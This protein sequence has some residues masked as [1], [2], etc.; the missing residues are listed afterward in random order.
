MWLLVLFPSP[1]LCYFR[2]FYFSNVVTCNKVS[3]IFRK[4]FLLLSHIYVVLITPTY[5]YFSRLCFTLKFVDSSETFQGSSLHQGFNILWQ[6]VTRNCLYRTIWLNITIALVV[7]VSGFE[8]FDREVKSAWGFCSYSFIFSED[9]M[10]MIC[11][12][13]VIHFF[14]NK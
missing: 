12:F 5:H 1:L 10:L 11:L 6:Y 2:Y 9:D 4:R 3:Y 7:N 13:D 14:D 8:L